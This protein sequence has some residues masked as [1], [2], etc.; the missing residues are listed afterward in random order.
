[1]LVLFNQVEGIYLLTSKTLQR[2]RTV[3]LSML[4]GVVENKLVLRSY[5]LP[6]KSSGQVNILLLSTVEILG[7][8]M[9][10]GKKKPAIGKLYDF[11]KAGMDVWNIELVLRILAKPNQIPGF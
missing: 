10:D 2:E 11:T 4:L 9:G 7:V 6:T 8:R 5:V 3:F 1:M